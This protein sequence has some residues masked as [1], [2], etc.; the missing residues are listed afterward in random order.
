[1]SPDERLFSGQLKELSQEECHERLAQQQVGRVAYCDEEGPV[2]VPV[3]Y[4]WDGDGVLLRVSPHTTLARA[5]RSAPAAFEV[6]EFDE[7]T[8]SGWSVL[9]RGHA[10]YVDAA[11]HP[12]PERLLPW[13]A[14]QRGLHVRI[15]A[16]EIT[17]RR[18]VPS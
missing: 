1:V 10:E 13:A 16:R 5:L 9:V 14:G 4:T 11:D 12:V 8:Q 7:Y 3:N 18:I 15:P 2:V 6:D 17:G